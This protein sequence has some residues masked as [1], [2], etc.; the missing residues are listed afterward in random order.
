MLVVLS[1]AV[2]T[3]VATFGNGEE[4]PSENV[5]KVMLTSIHAGY[6]QAKTFLESGGTA[7]H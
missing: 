5:T 4:E 2:G 6:E 1:R 3:L 7:C